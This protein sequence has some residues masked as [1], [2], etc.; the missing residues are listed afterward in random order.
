[1]EESDGRSFLQEE[2]ARRLFN[3]WKLGQRPDVNKF[4]AEVAP[5][6]SAQLVAVLR[7][8]QVE[9]W[10]AGER[11]PV[12]SYLMRFPAV[13]D[14]ALDLIYGECLIRE[15]LGETL[16]LPE[17]Q[18]RFP[19]F[20]ESVT[21]LGAP[22]AAH[23]PGQQWQTI[24]QTP[25]EQALAK[26]TS[27]K[28]EK[29]LTLPGF[30]I[31][32]AA[33]GGGMGLVYK[34]RQLDPDRVV[35][36]KVIRPEQVEQVT[37]LRRFEREV[38]A[39]VRLDHPNIV[40]FYEANQAGG[41]H[42]FVM[43]Y[44]HGIDLHKLVNE[45]GILPPHRACEFIRQAALGLQHAH[46]R[47]LVHRDIKPANIMVTSPTPAPASEPEK[48]DLK[49]A[50]LIQRYITTPGAVVK[51]LDMGLARVIS[52]GEEQESWSTLTVAGTFM[53]TPDYMAPE[54]WENPHTTD[55]RADIYS[56]GC[57][58]YFLLT[59]QP[60]FPGGSLIQ[61]LDKHRSQM[62]VPAEDMR[63][64][65]PARLGPVLRKMLNKRPAE[66]HQTPSEVAA[67]LIGL[68]TPG[69]STYT[70]VAVAR[71]QPPGEVSQ[72][73]G[74]TD[75][76][77]GVAVA[78]N[79][80]SLVSAG[81]DGIVRVWD[82]ATGRA[83]RLVGH[84]GGV[85]CIAYSP[86][87]TH[88]LSGGTDRTARL[89]LASSGTP[90]RSLEHKD[91]V[92]AVAFSADSRFA[93]TGCGDRVLRLWDVTSGR[94]MA[95]FEGHSGDISCVLFFPDNQRLLSS[96]WDKTARLWETKTGKELRCFGGSATPLQWLT[97]MSMAL[98]SDGTRLAV[99]GSDNLLRVWD[100][101]DGRELGHYPGHT[102]WITT[103]AFSSDG[104]HLLTGSR[105]NT[106]RLWNVAD[107]R[108][109]Y[110]FRGHTQAVTSVCFSIDGRHAFSASADA[111]IRYWRLP[112]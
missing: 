14:L 61:K 69:S 65:L 33:G 90:V 17:Y 8:D 20:A 32:A 93:L 60:P 23:A 73:T 76:V 109:C 92:K 11:V 30:E 88:I 42:F 99:G 52:G 22:T 63:P 108:E 21:A 7:V 5:L 75:A 26:S 101:V 6:S 110:C 91:A 35:A 79:G 107:G 27:A 4:V 39:A 68:V 83:S 86:N 46:D 19:Q 3:L 71:A 38:R 55:I 44:V 13:K 1:M 47:G 87:G 95:R 81:Q 51:I 56:L 24:G 102:D 77:H 54:Q 2:T 70:A 12:E 18:Q 78:P 106:V 10:Q 80:K 97:I 64:G 94:R 37:A 25:T 84:T 58:L 67:A 16:S 62:P 36:L 50:A 104:R 96:S 34:A 112:P 82:L 28:Q 29:S 103:V 53:G 41:Q 43:E 59:G 9:R 57:L 15:K 72:L 98:S 89:W 45:T 31:L 48:P 105:D 74:H 40:R 49:K 85:K 111:T 100:A 66:R